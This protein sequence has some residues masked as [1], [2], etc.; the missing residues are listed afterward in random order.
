MLRLAKVAVTGGLS[1]GKSSACHFFKELGAYVVSADEIVDQI[2]SPH[3]S[4]GQKVIK[5]I[6]PEIVVDQQIDHAK[7]A[8]KVFNNPQLLH[9]LEALLH[10]AVLQALETSY[11]QIKQTKQYPLFV[12]E[13]PLLYEAGFESWFDYVIVITATREQCKERFHKKTGYGEEEFTKRSK[14]QWDTE[15]KAQRADSVIVNNGSLEELKREIEKIF[16][17]L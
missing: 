4:L 17:K 13:V 7:I 14:R 11:Q 16:I 8:K 10:P 15:L 3:T 1:C 5:L 6:G 9:S 2:L 12:A